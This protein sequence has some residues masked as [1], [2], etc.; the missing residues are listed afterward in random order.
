M[1]KW[2]DPTSH[3]HIS[4]HAMKRPQRNRRATQK[5]EIFGQILLNYGIGSKTNIGYGQFIGYDQDE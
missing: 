5:A 3:C 2:S 1:H 4:R